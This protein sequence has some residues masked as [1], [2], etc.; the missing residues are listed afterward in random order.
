MEAILSYHHSHLFIYSFDVTLQCLQKPECLLT[1]DFGTPFQQ[2]VGLFGRLISPWQ[3]LC[4]HTEQ[5]N[6]ERRKRQLRL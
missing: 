3:G 6:T 5:H 1:L 2:L 4:L